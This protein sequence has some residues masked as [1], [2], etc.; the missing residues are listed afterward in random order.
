MCVD[1]CWLLVGDGG[2]AMQDD[3]VT[4]LIVASQSGHAEVVGALL[5]S[6]AAVNQG[7]TVSPDGVLFETTTV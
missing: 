1:G 3:G 2:V 5:E 6:G 4:A 7:R